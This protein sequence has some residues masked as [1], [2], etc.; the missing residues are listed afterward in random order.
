MEN[1]ANGAETHL[2]L[3]RHGETEYNRQHIVQGRGVDV[4]LNDTGRAQA[5]AL[6]LRAAGLGLDAVLASTLTRARETAAIVAEAVGIADIAHYADLEEQSSAVYE[7][8]PATP[9][10]KEAS[11]SMRDRWLGGDYGYA[12]EGGESILD[13]QRR[14][15]AAID[16]IVAHHAG[17]RVMVVTHGRFLRILL[18]SLLP[19]YGLPRMESLKHRNTSVNHLVLRDG[20]YEALR[21]DCIAHLDTADAAGD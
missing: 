2:Y 6:A 21:I 18:A 11:N 8:T 4:P 13:V 14:G 7:G 12:V 10:L 15:L 16:H 5:R 1:A 19:E 17:R 20:R 9:Q 3:V